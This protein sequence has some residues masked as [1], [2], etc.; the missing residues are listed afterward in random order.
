MVQEPYPEQKKNKTHYAYHITHIELYDKNICIG[1][2][3]RDWISGIRKKVYKKN[4]KRKNKK[5]V[6]PYKIIQIAGNLKR[7]KSIE[8]AE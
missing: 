7:T 2:A 4:N 5:C 3:K 8:G 1:K 6:H